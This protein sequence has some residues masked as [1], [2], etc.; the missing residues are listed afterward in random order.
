V[1]VAG[2]VRMRPLLGPG[3]IAALLSEH[4]PQSRVR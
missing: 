3:P 4:E 2:L 1:A